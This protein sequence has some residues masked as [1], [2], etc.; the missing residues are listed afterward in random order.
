M[1][2]W[3]YVLSL[4]CPRDQRVLFS[5]DSGAERPTHQ[6]TLC[7]LRDFGELVGEIV[8]LQAGSLCLHLAR[9]CTVTL[10]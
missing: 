5:C 3:H 7:V 8:F 2:G 10:T 1:N 6:P 9:G 4:S